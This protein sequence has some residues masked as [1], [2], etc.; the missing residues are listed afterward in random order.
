MV[1]ESP[2]VLSFV[3]ANGTSAVCQAR[4]YTGRVSCDVV[5]HCIAPDGCFAIPRHDHGM[6]STSLPLLF[7]IATPEPLWALLC[8]AC[9]VWSALAVEASWHNSFFPLCFH[10]RSVALPCSSS[11]PHNLKMHSSSVLWEAGS[12]KLEWRLRQGLQ[13]VLLLINSSCH[14]LLPVCCLLVS[15]GNSAG[16][17]VIE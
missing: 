9:S 6:L 15:C 5:V 2:L 8:Q 1:N 16:T 11:L 14:C 3:W 13:A 17:H 12:W 7:L 4:S 10:S